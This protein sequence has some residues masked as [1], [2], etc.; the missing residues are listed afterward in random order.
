M[1]AIILFSL[2]PESFY[3]LAWVMSVLLFCFCFFPLER[4]KERKLVYIYCTQ[5]GVHLL[6]CFN[7][8]SDNMLI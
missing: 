5:E 8:K 7:H 6:L 1:V 2:E 4:A 3:S